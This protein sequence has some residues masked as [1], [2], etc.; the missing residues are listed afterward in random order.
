MRKIGIRVLGEEPHIIS[1]DLGANTDSHV[2]SRRIVA[3]TAGIPT[4]LCKVARIGCRVTFEKKPADRRD[5]TRSFEL[6]W[7]NSCS[8]QNDAHG[9]LIQRLLTDHGIEP[10]RPVGDRSNGDQNV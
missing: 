9:I 2:L 1:I 6:A 5:K 10:K 3:V 8:L 7:P 4:T